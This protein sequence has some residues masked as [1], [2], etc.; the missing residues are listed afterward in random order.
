MSVALAVSLNHDD[1]NEREAERG[2]ILAFRSNEERLTF[3][4]SLL[5]RGRANYFTGYRDSGGDGEYGL[6]YG[7]ADWVGDGRVYAKDLHAL[8]H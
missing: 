7:T 1:V 8:V 5:A 4:M 2:G 6:S 3:A